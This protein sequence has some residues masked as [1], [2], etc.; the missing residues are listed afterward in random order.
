MLIAPA[1]SF[2]H[3]LLFPGKNQ[4]ISAKQTCAVFYRNTGRKV[5]V[6]SLPSIVYNS[7]ELCAGMSFT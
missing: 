4:A 2:I 6:T 3:R 1:V 7:Q 5:P